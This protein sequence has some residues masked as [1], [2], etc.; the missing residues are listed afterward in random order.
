MSENQWSH[1]ALSKITE[2]LSLS[3]DETAARCDAAITVLKSIETS[4]ELPL[5]DDQFADFR[6]ALSPDILDAATLT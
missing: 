3:L 4:F 5:T 6:E 2:P 1:G